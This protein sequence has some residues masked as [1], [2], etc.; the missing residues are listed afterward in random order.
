MTPEPRSRQT[1]RPGSIIIGHMNRPAGHTAEGLA[2]ALPR[3]VAA[4]HMF[5]RLGDVNLG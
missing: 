1:V 5:A 2:L 3:L 4:G